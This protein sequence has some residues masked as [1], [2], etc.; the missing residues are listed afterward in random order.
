[1]GG[2]S[3]MTMLTYLT[4]G[5]HSTSVERR[6]CVELLLKTNQTTQQHQSNESHQHAYFSVKCHMNVI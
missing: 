5:I 6:E 1:M 4:I 2:Q 3:W